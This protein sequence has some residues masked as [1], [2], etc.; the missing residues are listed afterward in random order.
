MLYIEGGQHVDSSAQQHLHVF[1]TLSAL[2]PWRVSV[3]QF[4]DQ[5]WVQHE[6]RKRIV[7]RFQKEGIDMPFPTRTILL[8]DR[9]LAALGGADGKSGTKP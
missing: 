5:Y 3:R 7:E 9:A 2:R 1:P 4:V 8:E 6:L